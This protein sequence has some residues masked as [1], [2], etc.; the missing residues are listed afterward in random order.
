M[1]SGVPHT[2]GAFREGQY[3]DKIKC[4]EG[5]ESGHAGSQP[6]TSGAAAHPDVLCCT[7]RAAVSGWRLQYKGAHL[8]GGG[9]KPG[10]AAAQGVCTER[11][12][13]SA[14]LAPTAAVYL[15]VLS[16]AE[17]MLQ[18]LAASCL[19]YRRRPQGGV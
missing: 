5:A 17:E 16:M 1:R 18:A 11:E 14:P 9:K 10:A 6:R 15:R 4:K 2:C 12:W 8:G 13:G 3:Q 19:A 7:G